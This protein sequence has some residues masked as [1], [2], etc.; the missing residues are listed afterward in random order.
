MR[1]TAMADMMA[2]LAAWQAGGAYLRDSTSGGGW[3]SGARVRSARTDPATWTMSHSLRTDVT[4]LRQGSRNAQHATSMLQGADAALGEIDVALADMRALAVQAAGGT[5]SEAELTA[6]Q[7]TF[8]ERVADIDTIATST[9]HN[10]TNLL[11]AATGSVTIALGEGLADPGGT[12]RIRTEDMTAAGLGLGG[13]PVV[14]DPTTATLTA[15]SAY[16]VDAPDDHYL[17]GNSQNPGELTLTFHGSQGDK[18]VAISLTNKKSLDQVVT[19]INDEAGALVPGWTAA[20]AVQAGGKWVLKVSTYE[21]GESAAPTVGVAGDLKWKEGDV[22][23]QPSDFTGEAGTAGG[24][25]GPLEVTDEDA[26]DKIDAAIAA[27]EKLRASHSSSLNRLELAGSAI[28]SSLENLLVVE[29]RLDDVAA[30]RETAV[31]TR[32]EVLG[33]AGLALM[34]QGD[35]SGQAALNLLGIPSQQTTPAGILSIVA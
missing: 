25:T 6:M 7:T 29:S 5:H 3:S 14:V 26:L 4:R 2:H 35:I 8:G 28:G 12:V 21:A 23:V 31:S 24:V 10:G 19:M 22:A 16:G 32:Q 27:V 17:K 33:R 11:T 30:A 1:I 9:E 20:E 18:A 34:L 13:E 15:W